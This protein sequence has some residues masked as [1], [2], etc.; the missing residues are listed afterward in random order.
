MTNSIIVNL[1]DD[2]AALRAYV[3]RRVTVQASAGKPVSAVVFG[4]QVTQGGLVHLYFDMR[5]QH[6]LDNHWT[7]A[8]GL[9]QDLDLPHWTEAFDKVEVDGGTI[10]LPTGERRDI[11]AGSPDDISSVF[12]EAVR[13]IALDAVAAGTFAPLAFREGCDLF[14]EDFD[15][16]WGFKAPILGL[17]GQRLPR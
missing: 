7:L 16:M 1:A 11:R 10:V 2:T 3:A 14:V 17:Q 6:I 4:Y 12:G 5:P 9:G 8:I 15:G 13:A